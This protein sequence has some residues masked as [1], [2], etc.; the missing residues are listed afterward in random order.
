MND[1][2]PYIIK[3]HEADVSVLILNGTVEVLIQRIISAFRELIKPITTDSGI[4]RNIIIEK[5]F[6]FI[7]TDVLNRFIYFLDMYMNVP[8]ELI[9]ISETNNGYSMAVRFA[10]ASKVETI[11]KAASLG[12][13]NSSSKYYEIIVDL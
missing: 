4:N 5:G 2:E 3:D 6:Q 13:F 12:T 1:F 7:P 11:P 9:S 10:T 8:E